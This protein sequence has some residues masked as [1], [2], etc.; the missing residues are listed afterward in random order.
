MCERLEWSDV[1]LLRAILVFLDTQTWC[2]IIPATQKSESQEPDSE[3]FPEYKVLSEVLAA[4][5]VITTTFKEPLHTSG[6]NLLGLQ[7]EMEEAVKYAQ[8]YLSI[9]REKCHKVWYNIHIC[10]D[11]SRWANVLVFFGIAV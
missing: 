9:E 8:Q 2:P 6:V 7:D 5:D 11:A 1:Q 3:N 10:A 4:G